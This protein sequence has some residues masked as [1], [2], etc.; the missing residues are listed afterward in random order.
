VSFADEQAAILNACGRVRPGAALRPRSPIR[1]VGN[2]ASWEIYREDDFAH[3]INCGILFGRGRTDI[4]I[5]AGTRTRHRSLL[6]YRDA[7]LLSGARIW[8]S[9]SVHRRQPGSVTGRLGGPGPF[10]FNGR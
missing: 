1:C 4:P 10:I 5:A 7:H 8:F 3:Q 2:T 9:A 6:E